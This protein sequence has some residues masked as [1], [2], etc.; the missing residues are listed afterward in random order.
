[1]N[2]HVR[3]LSAPAYHSRSGVS[4]ELINVERTGEDVAVTVT[5][6][7]SAICLNHVYVLMILGVIDSIVVKDALIVINMPDH[8]T[9]TGN[10]GVVA[11]LLSVFEEEVFIRAV[12]I[13]DI[14]LI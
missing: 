7:L 13:D 2:T 8:H 10:V 3:H 12:S 5:F 6:Q 4:G 9:V 1:M 11:G 14:S